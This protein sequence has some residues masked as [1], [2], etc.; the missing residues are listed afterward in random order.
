MK[1]KE[2]HFVDSIPGQP[3]YVMSDNSIRIP[4]PDGK[5]KAMLWINEEEAIK[6]LTNPKEDNVEFVRRQFDEVRGLISK[7]H[8]FKMKILGG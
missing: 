6:S 2:I 4:F 7:V 3:V 5:T 8:N 1:V